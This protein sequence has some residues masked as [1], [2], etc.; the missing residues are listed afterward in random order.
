MYKQKF[1]NTSDVS[2]FGYKV[3]EQIEEHLTIFSRK[4]R[5]NKEKLPVLAEREVITR[6]FFGYPVIKVQSCFD[7]ENLFIKRKPAEA[8]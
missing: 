3:Y 4:F 2:I 1:T 5:N 6:K 8:G 7:P